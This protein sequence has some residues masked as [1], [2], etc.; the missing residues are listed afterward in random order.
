MEAISVK[1]KADILIG[2]Y[3]FAD[4][5]KEQVKSLLN[6]GVVA[7]PQD[8]SNTIDGNNF[9]EYNQIKDSVHSKLRN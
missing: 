3:Q 9:S 1:H 6:K 8:D 4:K 2:E 7:I 5:V